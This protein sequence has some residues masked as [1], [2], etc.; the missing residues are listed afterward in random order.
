M[1]Q[2][3]IFLL[4]QDTIFL[5]IQDTIPYVSPKGNSFLFQMSFYMKFDPWIEY[6]GE[7]IPF[8]RHPYIYT[9]KFCVVDD[10]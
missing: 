10:V 7:L 6:W 1:I 5:M 9:Y 3:T 4:T 2:D 8:H